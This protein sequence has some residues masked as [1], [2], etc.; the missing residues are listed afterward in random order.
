M[1]CDLYH[2]FWFGVGELLGENDSKG[3]YSNGLLKVSLV[4]IQENNSVNLVILLMVQKSS[5]PVDIV[6]YP[7]IYR[8]LYIPGGA[9]FLPTACEFILCSNSAVVAF[10]WTFPHRFHKLNVKNHG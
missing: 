3:A 4:K 7:I 9:G 1:A 10:L 2:P 5:K 6:V 8:V